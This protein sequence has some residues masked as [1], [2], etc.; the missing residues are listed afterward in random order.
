MP[1]ENAEYVT[2]EYVTHTIDS[3]GGVRAR[4]GTSTEELAG[5]AAYWNDRAKR[6]E[7]SAANKWQSG[8]TAGCALMCLLVNAAWAAHSFGLY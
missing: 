4:K 2:P 8:F 6:A 1:N 7:Q 3:I 5:A